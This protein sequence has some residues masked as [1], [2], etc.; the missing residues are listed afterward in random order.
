MQ[1]LVLTGDCK[2]FLTRGFE[3]LNALPDHY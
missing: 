3:I 1:V 2:C